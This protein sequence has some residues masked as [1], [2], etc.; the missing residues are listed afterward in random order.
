M[1]GNGFLWVTAVSVASVNAAVVVPANRWSDAVLLSQRGEQ[2][3][4][5]VRGTDGTNGNTTALITVY[6]R[7]SAMPAVPTGGSY[8]FDTRTITAPTGW[9]AIIP[10]G[11]DPVWTSNAIA[12]IVGTSGTDTMLSWGTPGELARNGIDGQDELMVLM[13]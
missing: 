6:Q 2:G 5:G 9:S 4:Q 11:T 10:T 1:A 7:S 13:G 3:V 8:N 12:S